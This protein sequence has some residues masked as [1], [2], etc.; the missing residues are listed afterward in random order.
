MTFD[1]SAL[2]LVAGIIA[3]LAIFILDAVQHSAGRGQAMSDPQN[4]PD[5]AARAIRACKC[6]EELDGYEAEAKRR[7]IAAHELQLILERRKIMRW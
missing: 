5:D 1:G 3:A 2:L 4:N 7:G 6:R